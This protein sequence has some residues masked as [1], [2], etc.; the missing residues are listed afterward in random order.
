VVRGSVNSQRRARET[1]AFPAVLPSCGV[2]RWGVVGC[3]LALAIVSPARG[4]PAEP[5]PGA[6][7]A[8][9]WEKEVAALEVVDRAV[10]H[11][12]GVAFVGSSNIRLWKSLDDDFPGWRVHRRG[13]GG[14]HL[15]ELTPVVLR[16]LGRSKP[17]VIV[18]S[19]GINDIH[20]GRTAEQVAEA[21]AAFVTTV[22]EG[23]PGTRVVFL[24]IAPS[25]SRWDE[26]DEQARANALVWQ[27]IAAHP[28]WPLG[29]ADAG[30]AYLRPN[31]LP[32]PE[33]F[34]D[35]GLHPTRVGYARRAAVLRPQ[36]E[37]WLSP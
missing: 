6:P 31:G 20:A 27:F 28:D 23:L 29:Y 25:F 14:C 36:L 37:K 9:R 11:P 4:E 17:T 15:H 19:A 13:V 33:C 5:P 34:V 22:R 7:H 24:A 2:G 12:G 18:V 1:T 3:V 21:F 26:R 10:R 35:D 30:V 32:A 8:G 16:L